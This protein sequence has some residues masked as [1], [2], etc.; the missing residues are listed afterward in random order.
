MIVRKKLEIRLKKV[1]NKNDFISIF[2]VLNKKDTERRKEYVVQ[3][4]KQVFFLQAWGYVHPR[5]VFFCTFF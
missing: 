1:K 4:A 3:N 5:N 2:L